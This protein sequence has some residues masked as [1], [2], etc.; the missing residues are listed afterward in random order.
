MTYHID[1]IKDLNNPIITTDI[2]K[3]HEKIKYTLQMKTY[4]KLWYKDNSLRYQQSYAKIHS[5]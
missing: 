4:S 3:A 2:D 5:S 1:R